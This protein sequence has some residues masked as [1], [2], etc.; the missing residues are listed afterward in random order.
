MGDKLRSM[1]ND[2]YR[3]TGSAELDIILKQKP[4]KKVKPKPK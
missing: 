4:Q 2:S 3:T 1:I